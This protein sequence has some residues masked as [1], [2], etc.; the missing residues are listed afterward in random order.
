MNY[1]DTCS[2]VTYWSNVL[3]N[4]Y[5]DLELKVMDYKCLQVLSIFDVLVIP[6]THGWI[7]LILALYM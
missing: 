3:Q 2:V 4:A 5:P 1:F 7:C 6:Y